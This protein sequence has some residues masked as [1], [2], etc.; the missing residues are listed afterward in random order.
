MERRTHGMFTTALISKNKYMHT[1][2]IPVRHIDDVI[3]EIYKPNKEEVKETIEK[4]ATIS[5]DWKTWT[6][7]ILIFTLLV[8]SIT[9]Y[10]QDTRMKDNMENIKKQTDN[11]R[12]ANESIDR[13]NQSI[14]ESKKVLKEV[15]SISIQ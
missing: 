6:I 3:R 5:A 8:V 4:E 9:T 2:E 1:K 15:Y 11:I 13:S 14:E 12:R 10:L 7:G